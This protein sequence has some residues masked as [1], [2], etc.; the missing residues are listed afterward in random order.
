ML[1]LSGA[2]LSE[3]QELVRQSVECFST[4]QQRL[5]DLG[6]RAGFV[7]IDQ[8]RLDFGNDERNRRPQFMRGICDKVFLAEKRLLEARK[9]TIKGLSQFV[10]FIASV[11]FVKATVEA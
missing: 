5:E 8:C 2:R 10:E 7:R 9:H 11:A 6:M 3:K 4:F 1:R